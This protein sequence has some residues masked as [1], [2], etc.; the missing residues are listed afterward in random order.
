MTFRDDLDYGQK[1]EANVWRG[2][3]CKALG[4][5]RNAFHLDGAQSAAWDVVES[6]IC[7]E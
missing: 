6:I 7:G 1:A 4:I 2:I 5:L 3:A